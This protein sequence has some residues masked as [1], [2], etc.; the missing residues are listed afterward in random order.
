[1]TTFS[2]D[3]FQTWKSV[4]SGPEGAHQTISLSVLNRI[5]PVTHF[6]RKQMILAELAIFLSRKKLSLQ[7][8]FFLKKKS[9]DETNL[10]PAELTRPKDFTLLQHIQHTCKVSRNFQEKY[11]RCLG[12]CGARQ[13][14]N[15]E[16]SGVPAAVVEGQIKKSIFLTTVWAHTELARPEDRTGLRVGCWA[17]GLSEEKSSSLWLYVLALRLPPPG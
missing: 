14:P 16:C 13:V 6:W 5:K 9:S 2:A 17:A 10:G 11:Q 8:K 1:M 3:D 4:G 12:P 7:V 15:T